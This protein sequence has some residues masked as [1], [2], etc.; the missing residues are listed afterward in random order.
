MPR[1]EIIHDLRWSAIQMAQIEGR[2]HRDGR[3]AQ[4]YWVYA[5][6]TIE[7]RIARVVARRIQA[8]KEMIG[9]ETETL[10]EIERLLDASGE[11]R[12]EA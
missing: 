9:D 4:V 2:C 1:S 12:D 5:D 7:E 8:M 3:F 11:D 6:R 10:R